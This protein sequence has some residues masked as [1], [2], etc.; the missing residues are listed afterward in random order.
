ML[1]YSTQRDVEVHV[2]TLLPFTQILIY[3]LL[4]DASKL[5]RCSRLNLLLIEGRFLH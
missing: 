1:Q 4:P 3:I 2:H 5:H